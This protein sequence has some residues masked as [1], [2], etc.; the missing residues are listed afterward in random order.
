MVAQREARFDP[1]ASMLRGLQAAVMLSAALGA[2][3]PLLPEK[4]DTHVGLF[5]HP[6]RARLCLDASAAELPGRKSR[7]GQTRRETGT[8]S[9][10]SLVDR[11]V[12]A[13]KTATSDHDKEVLRCPRLFAR[14]A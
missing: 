8:Q 13:S 14:D 4:V 11:P 12:A 1:S 2:P 9:Q 5:V 10:G 6:K 3:W 7:S